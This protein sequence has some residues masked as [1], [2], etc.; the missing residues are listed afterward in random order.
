MNNYYNNNNIIEDS[1]SAAK[2]LSLVFD[3][4]WLA[5]CSFVR[6]V[7]VGCNCAKP[8]A[9]REEEEEESCKSTTSNK[10]KK[11]E[12]RLLIIPLAMRECVRVCVSL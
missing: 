5:G 9:K 8:V 2:H 4:P 11:C 1:C 6:P 7:S 3:L 10:I 12:G